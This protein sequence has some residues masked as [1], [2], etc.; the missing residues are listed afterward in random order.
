MLRARYATRF[1]PPMP[2]AIPR[3]GLLEIKD[4]ECHTPTGHHAWGWAEYS[5]YLTE[6][7]MRNYELEFIGSEEVK[8]S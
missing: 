3:N 2:G 7:E 4:E 8:C 6:D 5:R 1:R